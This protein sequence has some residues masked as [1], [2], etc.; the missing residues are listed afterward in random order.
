[1]A[2][3]PS[4][5]V[6]RTVIAWVAPASRSMAP[7]T[8]TTPVVLLMAKRPPASSVSEYVTPELVASPSEA[9]AVMP[10]VVP[11]VAFSVTALAAALVSLT[12]VTSNS[13][14]SL[15]VMV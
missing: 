8:V 4:A 9:K 5:E 14:A 10:T 15:T 11:I 7:A 3:E 2:I 12:G 13:S 6:A 1:M